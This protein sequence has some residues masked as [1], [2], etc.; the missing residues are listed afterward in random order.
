LGRLQPACLGIGVA[1][2]LASIILYLA[3]P[4]G[5]M[6]P[7]CIRDSL[8]SENLQPPYYNAV[9]DVSRCQLSWT[10]FGFVP[11]QNRYVQT[12]DCVC[13]VFSENLDSGGASQ[14]QWIQP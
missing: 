3:T 6:K 11:K 1:V 8:P 12:E 7:V 14:I 2:I 9:N 4:P 10:I 13:F 5:P